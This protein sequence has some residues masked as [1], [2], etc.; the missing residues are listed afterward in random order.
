MDGEGGRNRGPDSR[1][2]AQLGRTKRGGELRVHLFAPPYRPSPLPLPSPALLYRGHPPSPS[3]SSSYT[4]SVHSC[5]PPCRRCPI[6]RAA[7][8]P[9]SSPTRDGLV[10]VL[11]ASAGASKAP[12][13]RCLVIQRPS[14]G[15]QPG[16]LAGRVSEEGSVSR[17]APW[18]TGTTLGCGALRTRCSRV[19]GMI[20]VVP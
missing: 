3:F 19:F 2:G 14:G 7:P 15:E 16:T 10:V 8:L 4:M 20:A 6:G 5:R 12:N 1:G 18:S 9:S 11:W 13:L 17:S